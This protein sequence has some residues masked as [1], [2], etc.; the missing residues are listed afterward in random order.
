MIVNYLPSFPFFFF[1]GSSPILAEYQ[2]P[3]G[4]YSSLIGPSALLLPDVT[5]KRWL[6]F[7]TLPSSAVRSGLVPF[8]SVVFFLIPGLEV[9]GIHKLIRPDT[10]LQD[11]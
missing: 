3:Q 9:V 5:P 4:V 1:S 8:E 6:C 2:V 11:G 10:W 7:L